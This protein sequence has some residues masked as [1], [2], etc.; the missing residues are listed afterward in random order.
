[1]LVPRDTAD[2]RYGVLLGPDTAAKA[3][4]VTTV[5]RFYEIVHSGK[6]IRFD[7]VDGTSWYPRFQ[8]GMAELGFTGHA[9][10]AQTIAG[11]HFKRLRREHGLNDWVLADIAL[12]MA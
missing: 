5:G 2:D 1:M 7:G 4:G 11:I 12:A 9:L 10:D 3:L 8:F 6:V